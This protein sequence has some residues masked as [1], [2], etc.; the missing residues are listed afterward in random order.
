M[1]KTKYNFISQRSVY[2]VFYLVNWNNLLG[3]YSHTWLH[4]FKTL[5]KANEYA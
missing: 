1:S 5:N 2:K 4:S 3:A